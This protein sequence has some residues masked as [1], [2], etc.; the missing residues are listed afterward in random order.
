VE[1][2]WSWIQPL[3]DA[4]DRGNNRWLPEYPAS[5]WGPVESDR[6]IESEGRRWRVL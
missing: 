3:L 2:S 4:W 6:L 5:T 1:A